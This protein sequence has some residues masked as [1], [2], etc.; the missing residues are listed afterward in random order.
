MKNKA[1]EYTLHS[2]LRELGLKLT[3]AVRAR[4]KSKVMTPMVW[5]G[6]Y[7]LLP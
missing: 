7:V 6:Y 5:I 4:P 1:T 2:I 3:L